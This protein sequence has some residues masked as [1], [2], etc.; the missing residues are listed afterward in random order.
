MVE[1]PPLVLPTLPLVLRLMDRVAE[2]ILKMGGFPRHWSADWHIARARKSLHQHDFSDP[3]L[4]HR[5]QAQLDLLHLDHGLSFTGR[6]SMCD[7]IQGGLR[8]YLHLQQDFITYPEILKLPVEQP[9]FILGFPRSGTT[10]L[11][12]LLCCDPDAYFLSASDLQYPFPERKDWGSVRDKR[13][14]VLQQQTEKLKQMFPV[15]DQIHD[16]SSPAECEALFF[17]NFVDDQLFTA[18]SPD[19]MERWGSQVSDN[20][21]LQTYQFHRQQL[22]HLNWYKQGQSKTSSVSSPTKHWVLKHIDHMRRLDVLLQVYPDARIIQLFRDPVKFVASTAN[23][24]C[25]VLHIHRKTVNPVQIG[26]SVLKQ[27]STWGH[28]YQVLREGLPS[29]RVYDMQYMDLVSDPILSVEQALTSFGM[30]MTPAFKVAI[31]DYVQ[32]RHGHAH[33]KYPYHPQQFG[34]S[35]DS[36]REAF[37]DYCHHFNVS[38]EA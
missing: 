34:L 9:I 29:G 4:H 5:L 26:A 1:T 33:K 22:Q 8:R 20:D 10:F 2:P 23:L 12:N 37:T 15:I 18:Y 28:Q 21:W 35:N 25:Q 16:F 7:T 32:N 17:P 3:Y 24:A 11:Q 13:P 6:M 38:L 19:F 14:Q 30:T 31:Q 36:V 27:F